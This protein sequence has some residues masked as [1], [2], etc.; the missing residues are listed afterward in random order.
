MSGNTRILMNA[1]LAHEIVG[2]YEASIADRAFPLYGLPPEVIKR[3]YAL[4]EAQASIRAARFAPEI[5]STERYALL[6]D[7][8]LRLRNADLRVR[9]VKG[10]LFID[11]R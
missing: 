8:M 4:N 2:H 5:H 3:N 9:D 10:E 11:Q 1:T 7:A 6:R